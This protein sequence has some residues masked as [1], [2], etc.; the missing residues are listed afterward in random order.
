[1]SSRSPF[2][3]AHERQHL[4]EGKTHL[5]PE[6]PSAELTEREECHLLKH[7]HLAHL[8]I[9]AQTKIETSCFVVGNIKKREETGGGGE[10][11]NLK[12]GIC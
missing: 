12:K 5:L 4:Q 1:M 10:R 2:S 11:S 6:P 3:T 8:N 9:A 7:P